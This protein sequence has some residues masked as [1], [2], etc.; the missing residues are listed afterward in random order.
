MFVYAPECLNGLRTLAD[1]YGIVLI[2]DEIATGLGRTGP[3]FAGDWA[4]VIPDTL[5]VGKALTG[6]Y[7]SLAAMLCTSAVAHGLRRG[8]TSALLHGPTFMANPL[9]CAVALASLTLLRAT[10]EDAVPRIENALSHALLPA[11]DVSSVVDVRVLG[12]VGVIELDRPV[13]VAAVT[14]AAVDRGVWLRP[15][16]NLVYTMPP[17]VCTDTEV[18][19]IATAMT[20]VV[21]QV[22]G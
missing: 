16:R 7:L 21:A 9:A 11:A 4:G 5:C 3:T 10:V 2:F 1:R 6:G 13:D 12:A 22:H 14:A 15:F 18:R 17:Y 19:T 8:Q 20:N